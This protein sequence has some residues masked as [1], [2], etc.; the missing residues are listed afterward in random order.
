M[1][2]QSTHERFW[3]KVDKS[4][5]CWLW[6]GTVNG[7]GYGSLYFNGKV[8]GTH[9]VSFALTNGPIPPGLIVCH[10]C[11]N[12]PCVR[13]E[14][15]FLGTYSENALDCSAKGRANGAARAHYG[16][17]HG[18]AK[19]TWDVVREIRRRHPRPPGRGKNKGGVL[20]SDTAREFGLS[21]GQL[22]A[23]VAKRSW[24][25]EVMPNV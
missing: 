16:E 21:S 10:R 13:P 5:E 9:R 7:K 6:T 25:E 11:D 14:H 18:R 1:Q 24:R 20:L 23:I 8:E 12:P 15:L 19:V 3:S 2:S 17:D 4:G 22:S